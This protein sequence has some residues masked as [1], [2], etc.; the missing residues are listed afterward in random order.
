MR[1]RSQS[2]ASSE[3]RRV[4]TAVD[5]VSDNNSDM[6][7]VSKS[8]ALIISKLQEEHRSKAEELKSMFAQ[9]RE[10]VERVMDHRRICTSPQVRDYLD[11]CLMKLNRVPDVAAI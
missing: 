8:S 5:I 2:K 6:S 11:D 1:T 7:G 4:P 9:T 3:A 10:L